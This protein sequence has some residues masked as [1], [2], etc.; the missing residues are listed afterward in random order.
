MGNR[1]LEPE[2]GPDKKTAWKISRLLL[3]RICLYLFIVEGLQSLGI[4]GILS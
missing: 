1:F 2:I 3:F 4:K